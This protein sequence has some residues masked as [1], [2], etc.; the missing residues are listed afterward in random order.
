MNIISTG[1]FQS[2]MIASNRQPSVAEKFAA[3]WEKKNA[4][5]AQAGGVSLMALSLAACGSSSST[6]TT[7]S[8]DTTTTTTTATAQAFDLTAGFDAFT[9]GDGND[10][11]TST[12][13]GNYSIDDTLV[14]GAG[15]DTLYLRAEDVT[16]GAVTLSGIEVVDI[17]TVAGGSTLTLT[18]AQDVTTV[19]HNAGIGALTVNGANAGTGIEIKSQ[20]DTDAT[21]L[22]FKAGQLSGDADTV[23]VTLNGN[24]GAHTLTI[25]DAS[26]EIET[27]NIGGSTAS[28][29]ITTLA[30]DALDATKVTFTNT[31]DV[32]TAGSIT[33]KTIDA[34]AATGG[35]TVVL[36]TADVTYTGGSGK[37]VVLAGT[38]YD[39]S[40]T[41]TGGAGD[42]DTFGVGDAPG[43]TDMSGVSGFETLRIT[44]NGLSIDADNIG[45][46][47]KYE[48]VK[49]ND[50]DALTISDMKNGA[51]ISITQ[52]GDT[53]GGELGALDFGLKANSVSDTMS[54]SF[55]VID[56]TDDELAVSS[57]DSNAYLD[58]LTITTA[59]VAGGKVTITEYDAGASKLVV[60]GDTNFKIT[61]IDGDDVADGELDVIDASALTGT[62]EAVLTEADNAL[63]VQGSATKANTVTLSGS[64]DT[65]IGGSGVDNITD[66][67]GVD[68]IT[69]GAGADVFEVNH[70]LTGAA[71]TDVIKDFTA[72]TGGDQ[73]E[74]DESELDDSGEIIAATVVTLTELY[75]ANDVVGGTNAVKLQYINTAETVADAVNILVLDGTHTNVAAAVDTLE[76]GA[77]RALTVGT[78]A[79]DA[80]HG[81][82]LVWTDG[83]DAYVSAV[84]NEAES[85][86][87][88]A[89]EVGDLLGANLVKLEGISSIAETTFVAANF[90]FV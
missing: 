41:I 36:G 14:G 18:N 90:E 29:A 28:T 52:T 19:V 48:V 13:D 83:T 12:K 25:N 75:D 31:A 79:D 35:V 89:Y 3:V 72:G 23:N 24:T 61:A 42:D 71:A 87:N 57:L 82:I 70:Y 64:G 73:I 85:T 43:A 20:S 16:D 84:N 6:T 40:D 10:T 33:S 45:S 9:G 68:T 30:G 77:S 74:L 21:T 26:G 1:A 53:A 56:G 39:K 59:G 66:A 4:K 65:Y 34:S 55:T 58:T 63:V 2:E 22:N 78:G 80:D 32:L 5:A 88:T 67:A 17:R 37:D 27:L 81:F 8:T 60:N 54:I 47:N 62:F 69:F 7:S 38:T 15:T 86:G 11:F 44:A 50:V 46:I 49:A 76:A 51:S